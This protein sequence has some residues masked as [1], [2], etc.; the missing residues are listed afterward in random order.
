MDII[1]LIFNLWREEILYALFFTLIIYMYIYL[2]I[3]ISGNYKIVSYLPRTHFRLTSI[4]HN[5]SLEFRARCS[6]DY[7]SGSNK[8]E[9]N[10]NTNK[11]SYTK[12]YLY[13]LFIISALFII[14]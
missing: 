1:M 2:C 13:L 14:D 12:L 9:L 7:E 6:I 8:L 3:Y 4:F 5:E 11:L 10:I